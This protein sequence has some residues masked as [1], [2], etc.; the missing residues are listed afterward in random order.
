MASTVAAEIMAMNAILVNVLRRIAI[1]DP[2]L[3]DA[4]SAG[5]DDAANLAE[6]LTIAPRKTPT[7]ETAETLR[8]IEIVRIGVFGNHGNSE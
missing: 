2:K 8:I 5:F 7:K 1:S 4:I 3:S 6:Q